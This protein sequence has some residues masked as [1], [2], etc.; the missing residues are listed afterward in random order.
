MFTLNTFAVGVETNNGLFLIARCHN[1]A[2]AEFILHKVK[3]SNTRNTVVLAP[4][5]S[6]DR[7]VSH[8][9]AVSGWVSA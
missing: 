8:E 5:A 9:P 4:G 7:D 3:G 6:F 2:T 1:R